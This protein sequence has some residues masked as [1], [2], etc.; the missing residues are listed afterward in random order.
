MWNVG[1]AFNLLFQYDNNYQMQML[2]FYK[3]YTR[4]FRILS[5]SIL[6]PT[7]AF[8]ISKI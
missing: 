5:A 3:L 2:F 1:W 4:A 8:I 6:K 7:I